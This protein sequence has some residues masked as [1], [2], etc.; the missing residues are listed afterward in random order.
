MKYNKSKSIIF[1]FSIITLLL[2]GSI[3]PFGISADTASKNDST[4]ANTLNQK[5]TVTSIKTASRSITTQTIVSK[6][7]ILNTFYNP[8]FSNSD[9][10][11]VANAI[12]NESYPSMVVYGKN[13][14][15]SYEY[16]DGNDPYIYLRNSNNYG[17]S[18]SDPYKLVVKLDGTEISVNSP[19]L[20]IKPTS[21]TA[22]G[23]FL[24]K[25][26][27]S[28]THGIFNIYDIS[29]NLGSNDIKVWDWSNV[30]DNLGN[31]IGSWWGFKNIDIVYHDDSKIPWVTCFIGSTNYPGGQSNDSLMFGYLDETNS[32]YMY[33]TWDPNVEN[34]S[35]IS[36]DITNSPKKTL[37]GVCEIENGS[38]QDLLFFN[39]YP[40]TWGADDHLNYQI[41]SDQGNLTHPQIFVTGN[42]IYII[43][44]RDDNGYNEII[45]YYSSD[46][47][48]KWSINTIIANPNQP[49]VADFSW[50]ADRLDVNFTDKSMDVD[51]NIL[52]WDW[53]FGDGNTSTIQNPFHHYETPGAYTVNLT[54]KDDDNT[55]NMIS[56]TITVDNTTPIA[57]FIYSPLKP[58]ALDNIS[59]NDTSIPFEDHAIINWTWDFGDG[60]DLV[61]T[62][63]ATHQYLENGSYVVNLTVQDSTFVT[64]SV[65]K[66]TKVGLIADFTYEPQNPSIDD[67][68]FFNDLSSDSEAR[69]IVNWTWNF[70][71]GSDP[72]YLQNTSHQYYQPGVYQVDLTITNDLNAT[73]TIFKNIIVRSSKIIPLYPDIYVNVDYISC[74]FLVSKNLFITNSSDNGMSWSNPVQINSVDGSV[75]DGYRFA[76]I[77]DKNHILWTDN[78]AGNNDIY[79]LIRAFLEI[80]V[81]VVPE[82][83][84]ITTEGF[85]FL[86]TNN[87]I[88]YTIVNIGED[89][90]ENV[91][92]EVTINCLGKDPIKTDYPGYIKY[93]AGN[94]EISLIKPLF[95]ITVIEFFKALITYTG[96][97]NITITVDPDNTLDDIDRTNNAYTLQNITYGKIFPKLAWIEDIF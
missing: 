85:R 94:G 22:Y 13:A 65:E 66:T 15:V 21:K 78:R 81:M 53:D 25:F 35:N 3:G 5:G 19:T 44:E 37:Y 84:N 91:R 8:L 2:L 93:L 17:Q 33:I 82:S 38:K 80:D 92:I 26:N 96:I 4:Q 83:V 89:A 43:A 60:S 58:T 76:E 14:L 56:K 9:N 97:Q 86:Q 50:S 20:C 77:P 64:D 6:S 36:L 52:S 42:Q 18:W 49:P 70:G 12:G 11:V 51:G 79:S 27:N 59:F 1:A 88:K 10:I 55:E 48:K 16:N 34:C 95:R 47:G 73:T 72:I 57:D 45:L 28:G 87:W 54:V 63:N 46:G 62:Q 61:Y 67:T 74:I 69:T 31:Y 39:D 23:A 7:S 41:L 75:V 30:Y 40:I 32:N 24:T 71:D 29:G 68:I 90:V